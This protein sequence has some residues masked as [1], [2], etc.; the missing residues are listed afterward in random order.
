MNKYL[1]NSLA[2][3]KNM[4]LWG[5]SNSMSCLDCGNSQIFL[6]IMSECEKHLHQG[7]YN[8]RHNSVLKALASFLL[9]RGIGELYVDLGGFHLPLEATDNSKRPDMLTVRPDDTLYLVELT[10]CYETNMP[11][12][13][14]IKSNHYET[15]IKHLKSSFTC[16][17]FV[18]LVVSALGFFYKDSKTL[19]RMFE[20]FKITRKISNIAIRTSYYIFCMK[21]K[22]WS[23]PELM[24]Y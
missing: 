24:S 3:L 11:K 10:V 19:I 16:V 17:K 1:N 23:N 14:Q 15:T 9:P 6:H 8:W 4:L 22:S 12:N 7:C 21:D 2:T 5:T 13:A 18:N 20:D